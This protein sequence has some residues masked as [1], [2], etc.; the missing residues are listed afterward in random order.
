MERNN[1]HE[2]QTKLLA[3]N[4]TLNNSLSLILPQALHMTPSY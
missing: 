2:E 1:F 3:E 4:E